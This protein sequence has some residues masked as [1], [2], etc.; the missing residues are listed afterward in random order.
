MSLVIVELEKAGILSFGAIHDS[1]S[2]HAERV[3]E[4]LDITKETFINIYDKN[5]FKD[6]RNEII[7][8][9]PLF[10]ESE[11]TKG[12]LDLLELMKSDYFFC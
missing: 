6:M 7:S 2:V 10:V 4:L 3:D 9:D 5:I 8:N 11:P 1:F 12:K